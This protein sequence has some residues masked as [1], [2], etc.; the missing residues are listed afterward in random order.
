MQWA[1][2]QLIN[3]GKLVFDDEY[4]EPQRQL[5]TLILPPDPVSIMNARPERYAMDEQ[6]YRI[7][8]D[9]QQRYTMDG[10]ARLESNLQGA[11]NAGT[12]PG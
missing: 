3:T 2:T 1:G 8:Q 4:D 10:T 11:Q 7:T 12:Y 9:G 5:G 6:T